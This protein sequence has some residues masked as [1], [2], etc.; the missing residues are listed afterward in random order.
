MLIPHQKS[1][2]CSAQAFFA[3]LKMSFQFEGSRVWHCFV[4][5]TV[6][7]R[8]AHTVELPRFDLVSV[9]IFFIIEKILSHS[10]IKLR[11]VSTALTFLDISGNLGVLVIFFFIASISPQM[12]SDLVPLVKLGRSMSEVLSDVQELLL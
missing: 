5:L 9:L 2:C 3:V 1:L 4:L 7:V 11:I 8:S 12:T 10:E 6:T